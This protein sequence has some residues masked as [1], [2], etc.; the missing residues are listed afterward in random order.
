MDI[1]KGEE[2]LR[3]VLIYDKSSINIE[4]V[5]KSDLLDVL[6]NYMDLNSDELKLK[7][8]VDKFGFFEIKIYARTRRLKELSAVRA[9]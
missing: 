7:I 2:R 4:Q 3:Q 5:L 9:N 1:V 8:D 6:N